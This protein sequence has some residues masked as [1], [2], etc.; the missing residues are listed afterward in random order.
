M[1]DRDIPLPISYGADNDDNDTYR[2]TAAV[3]NRAIEQNALNLNTDK[4]SGK[5]ASIQ[6]QTQNFGG[7]ANEIVTLELDEAGSKLKGKQKGPANIY[8]VQVVP[9]LQTEVF[10]E[11]SSF[12]V[13]N[14]SCGEVIQELSSVLSSYS[15]EIDFEVDTGKNE[16]KNGVVFIN[17]YYSVFFTIWT[18]TENDNT[19][20]FEFR[21]QSGD[22]LASAKFLGEIKAKFFG[23]EEPKS[24]IGLE[25]NADDLELKTTE[26]QKEMMMIHEALI[27]DD[28]VGDTLEENA[29]N[30]LYQKLVDNKAIDKQDAIDHKILCKTLINKSML[31]HQ[32]VAVVRASLLI[33]KKFVGVYNE[34]L[35]SKTLFELLNEVLKT[36]RC[37][38]VKK[39][40]VDLLS[41]LAGSDE[42][43]ELD[44][45]VKQSLNAL[46]KG[47]EAKV[48][49]SKF[50]DEDMFKK[51]YQK[52]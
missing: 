33:L 26:S 51:V 6:A 43:W 9:S 18:A 47:Y 42:K 16:I 15:D 34:L 21:R 24:L 13:Q 32:D 4:M 41:Q 50:Y 25:L 40:T 11:V 52:V 19:T 36:Q 27:D 29:E 28:V 20:R 14:K 7:K 44:D 37:A 46:I 1:T 45:G 31:L 12:S 38:L 35:V 5:S 17:N 2:N 30:Y 39:Y 22:A 23:K 3:A 48:K 49:D 10:N 8:E